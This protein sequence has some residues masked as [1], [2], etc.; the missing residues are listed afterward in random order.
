MV[1][2]TACWFSLP[3]LPRKRLIK[4]N[5]VCS[6]FPGLIKRVKLD[7]LSFIV[8][9]FNYLLCQRLLMGCRSYVASLAENFRIIAEGFVCFCKERVSD[10]GKGL[11]SGGLLRCRSR[12]ARIA[13]T[14]Y[15]IVKFS[16]APS[17]RQIKLLQALVRLLR[18]H[19]LNG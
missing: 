4:N 17:C 11:F 1:F 10:N 2:F 15:F 13:G 5:A 3:L 19:F 16:V 12:A 7:E 8:Q 14:D 9:L 18:C 6:N